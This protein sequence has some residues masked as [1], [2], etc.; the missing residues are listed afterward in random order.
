MG[1]SER[2]G[3]GVLG[4]GYCTNVQYQMPTCER[5]F[6]DGSRQLWSLWDMLRFHADKFVELTRLLRS[7][8]MYLT[9]HQKFE[10][11]DRDMV[12]K[13]LDNALGLLTQINLRQSAKKVKKILG[14]MTLGGGA[15]NAQHFSIAVDEL[16]ERIKDEL[17]DRYCLT[18]SEAETAL[19]EP[20]AP[21]CGKDVHDNFPSAQYDISEAGKCM[22]LGRNTAVV[23]H[24]MRAL[25]PGLTA[26]AKEVGFTPLRDNWG[27]L[28]KEIEDRLDPKHASYIKDKDKRERLSPAAAQMRYFKDAWR[29]HAMHARTVYS[30]EQANI[31]ATAVKIFMM[32]L[33]NIGLKE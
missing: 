19:F 27:D 12:A 15:Y 28:I 23:M 29:N 7:I 21:L 16:Q 22:A 2:N 26:M 14:Q 13:E 8:V 20:Q 1:R 5:K 30:P 4:V 3:A 18:L 25:E 9:A 11:P 24:S 32:D 31:A 17:E 6:P 33:A 10:K